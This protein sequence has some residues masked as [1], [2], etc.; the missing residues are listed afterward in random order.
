[1]DETV[2]SAAKL[3]IEL[4]IVSAFSA[5]EN[6]W[7][8]WSPQLR[9]MRDGASPEEALA[10]SLEAM[11]ILFEGMLERGRLRE[12]L[13]GCGY[14]DATQTSETECSYVLQNSVLFSPLSYEDLELAAPF[15]GPPTIRK[16]TWSPARDMRQPESIRV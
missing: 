4:L 5:E 16:V 1:M 13:L 2:D 9:C 6:C 14:S 10:M 3:S 8:A 12:Y 15:S 11:E 7:Y